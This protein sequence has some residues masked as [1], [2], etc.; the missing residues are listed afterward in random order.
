MADA[1]AGSDDDV[2]DDLSDRSDETAKVEEK[3]RTMVAKMEK[4]AAAQAEGALT[5]MSAAEMQEI[6]ESQKRQIKTLTDKC[7]Q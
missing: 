6:I 5:Q 4:D 1:A 2:R 3:Y 7:K